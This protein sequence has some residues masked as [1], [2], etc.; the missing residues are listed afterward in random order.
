MPD[1]GK[2]DPSRII[3]FGQHHQIR[4]YK[5]TRQGKYSMSDPHL[6]SAEIELTVIAPMYNEAKNVNSTITS[7][8][9][10]LSTFEKPWEL[11]LIDDGS[12]DNTLEIARTAEKEIGNLRVISYPVNC[13]RGKA[14]RTGFA[15]ARG[16]YVITIDF[17][18]S[19]SPD[20]ILSIYEQLVDPSLM[21]DVVLGSA[22]MKGG[23]VV[24]VS[25]FRLFISKLGNKILEYTFPQSF[26]TSTCIL[27]GY[28]REVLDALELESNGKEIHLEILSKVCALGF[29][30]K[31]IPATLTSRKTGKSKFKLRKTSV[32]HLLF[33]IFER[34]ILLFGAVGILLIA[35]GLL[36][37]FYIVWLRYFGSL[38]PIRPLIPLMIILLIMG[39]QFFCFAFIASQNNHLRNQVYRLQKQLR[40]LKE[41]DKQE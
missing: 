15:H 5:M 19:Y 34:P 25:T 24:G 7:I 36:I 1:K 28:K 33:S 35:S 17:D 39:S 38:N 6:P 31:E 13:G 21:N 8:A 41:R 22:Y 29:R 23:K 14:L 10:L 30:V 26:K 12:T 4:D 16:K 3:D 32:T 2:R 9:Q 37:G 27:R 20:H 40:L 11:L 18:L